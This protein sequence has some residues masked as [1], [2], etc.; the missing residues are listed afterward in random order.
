MYGILVFICCVPFFVFELWD[1]GIVGLCVLFILDLGIV[2]FWVCWCLV[3]FSGC[4]DLDE[5][6]DFGIFGF[7][8][9]GILG[10]LVL[11]IWGI[12]WDCGI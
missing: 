12:C 8:V 2:G 6:L 11:G 10:V 1:C 5:F 4:L 9:V 3:E 7:G